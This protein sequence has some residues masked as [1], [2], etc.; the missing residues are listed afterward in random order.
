MDGASS[1][2][3]LPCRSRRPLVAAP[4]AAAILWLLSGAASAQTSTNTAGLRLETKIPLGAVRGR[5]DHMAIDLK[6]QHLFVAEL[7]NDSVG[8]VDLEQGKT[9]HTIGR[10][11]EPQ[12]VGYAPAADAIYVAN[13]RD[14]SV[15]VFRAADYAAVGR[16]DLG[17]DADN[18]RLDA[19]ANRVLIG[20]GS[21]A[22]SA[23][24]IGQQKKSGS[25]PLPAHPESF[26]IW[27]Q[28]KQIFVNV[29]VAHAVVVLDG[30]TGEQKDKWSVPEGGNFAMA[31]DP[32]NHRVLIVSR[33]PPK[34]IAYDE[35]DGSAIARTETCG[36]SDDVFTDAKRGRVYVSCGS[37]FIDVFEAQRDTYRRIAR[38][39][40][41]AG[42]RTSLFVPELDVL[43]LAVRAT[44]EEPAAIW[45]FR[46]TP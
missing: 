45:V 38:I 14:G 18:V 36:D 7:G 10:L 24:D 23:I 28:P 3:V 20:H 27:P 44:R 25:S 19:D 4:I 5:I 11:A 43:L 41:A 40:T 31:I 30:T 46:P 39:R 15:R 6:R 13:A 37:G 35:D 29:P 2:A 32:A 9:V 34:L 8:I 33:N 16:I 12:G 42:A 21:G 26:Q 17:S 22:I 1:Q